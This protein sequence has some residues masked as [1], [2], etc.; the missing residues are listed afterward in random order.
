[1]EEQWRSI[2]A[3]GRYEISN[4][5]NVRS[6]VDFHG[7]RSSNPHLLKPRKGS[8]GY[9]M[10]ILYFR[11]KRIKGYLVHRLVA[12]AFLPNINNYRCVNHKDEDKTNNK[13]DNLEWCTD[14]YNHNYGTKSE[15]LSKSLTNHPLLSKP[16]YQMDRQGNIIKEFP[17]VI[18][19]ARAI[20]GKDTNICK[21]CKN[22]RYRH[23]AYGYR[24][25]YKE[26]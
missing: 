18:E 19:A 7:K 4:Y 21:V 20:R 24:W 5:G 23:T 26:L 1:M 12:E 16:V 3:E 10:V 15:R 2:D 6:Y 9:L 8:H 14:K 13:V 17:S 25:K 11:G 22:E